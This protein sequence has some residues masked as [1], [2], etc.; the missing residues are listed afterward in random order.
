[1]SYLLTIDGGTTNT[2]YTLWDQTDE[3]I[4]TYR[5]DTGVRISA[6]TG[7]ADAYRQSLAEGIRQILEKKQ[8]SDHEILSVYASGMIT[9]SLG[10]Q[11]V[12][13]IPAPA[14]I[15]ELA[16]AVTPVQFPEIFPG[17]IHLIPGVK[18][19]MSTGMDMMRGEETEVIALLAALP[20]HDV[21]ATG[22]GSSHSFSRLIILPGSHNKFIWIS[23]EGKIERC[24]T[25]LSGEL[26]DAL[27]HHT[28]LADAVEHTF[29]PSDYDPGWLLAGAKAAD[30]KGL[31]AA[32]FETRIHRM[33]DGLSAPQAAAFLL[34]AVLEEDLKVCSFADLPDEIIVA[35]KEPLRSAIMYLLKGK[36]LSHIREYIPDDRPLAAYGALL[37]AR[38]KGDF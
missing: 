19:A 34:G 8:L 20:E 32:L 38:E 30:A 10:L 29:A 36:N 12:P 35:G 25:T 1:M 13:H 14:G 17:P 37:I 7:S 4:G 15:E 31:T 21:S 23:P 2:R 22:D 33:F 24:R 6:V 3:V 11:E 27:S 16:A 26:I 28:I 5:Q 9:S 18:N